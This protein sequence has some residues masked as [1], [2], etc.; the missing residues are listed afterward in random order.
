MTQSTSVPVEKGGE[1]HV[2]ATTFWKEVLGGL[3]GSKTQSTGEKTLSSGNATKV[4]VMRACM[5][6]QS[7]A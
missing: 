1:M 3:E 7:L 4:G 2:A 6:R 5:G